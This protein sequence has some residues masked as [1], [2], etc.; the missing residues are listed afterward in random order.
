M[1]A[2][3][4]K[5]S[6]VAFAKELIDREI[7]STYVIMNANSDCQSVIIHLSMYN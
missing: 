2:K 6:T 5:H 1:D 7:T 3:V 4:V